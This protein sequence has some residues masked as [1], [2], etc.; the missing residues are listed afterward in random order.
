MP[1]TPPL[2]QSSPWPCLARPH[3]VTPSSTTQF[4]IGDAQSKT[5]LAHPPKSVNNDHHYAPPSSR[6]P[7]DTEESASAA[8]YK[9]WPFQGFLKRVTIGNQITYNLEFSLSHVPEHLGLSLH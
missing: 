2:E 8:E 3:K 7:S 9:E 5:D 1:P 4:E 6:S